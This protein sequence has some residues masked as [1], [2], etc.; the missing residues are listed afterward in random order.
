MRWLRRFFNFVVLA[1][2]TICASGSQLEAASN[3]TH[4]LFKKEVGDWTIYETPENICV[5]G[6]HV[7]Y[8]EE[9]IVA[10]WDF[11]ISLGENY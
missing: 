11:F 5:M 6:A 2:L 7:L 4:E 1:S 9:R 3:D 8:E 10:Y